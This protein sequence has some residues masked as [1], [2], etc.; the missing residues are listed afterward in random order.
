MNKLIIGDALESLKKLPSETVQ[1]CVTSPPY[2]GL[3]DYGAEGQIG[4]ED[5]PEEYIAKLV[6][7]F[8]EVRRVLRKDG[9]LWLNLGDSYING[10]GKTSL[11]R[12]NLEVLKSR[13]KPQDGPREAVRGHSYLKD[14]DLVMIPARTAIALQQDGWWL[15][16]EIVWNKLNSLPESVED[17]PTR[18]HE[19]IYLLTKSANYYYNAEAIYE[20]ANYDG[21]KN[22]MVKGSK[23]YPNGYM[24]EVARVRGAKRWTK[25][26]KHNGDGTNGEGLEGQSGYFDEGG[27]LIGNVFANGIPARNK[28]DVWMITTASYKG[29]HFAT[30]PKE[31][32][33]LCIAAGSRKGDIVLDPF[34]G[35]GTTGEVAIGM[36]RIFWGIDINEKY[37]KELAEPRF[38]GS[39]FGQVV[40]VLEWKS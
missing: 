27:N 1:V 13:G 33:K 32:P 37:I 39:M 20:P 26:I 22:L 23:K 11:W 5:T 28:R 6:K 38:N 4:L 9:T 10:N 14:K 16:S 15:R 12:R 31:I 2:W 21:G 25:W 8:E 18:A 35:S 19:M 24:P 7:V 34:C 36:E 29:A 30:F 17:R 3:R 40:E